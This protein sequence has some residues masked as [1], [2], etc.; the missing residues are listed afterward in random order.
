M[1]WTYF[2]CH[3]PLPSLSL[4]TVLG[5][6]R[7]HSPSSSLKPAIKASQ[8]P[9]TLSRSHPLACGFGN[10]FATL[11]GL[12][13]CTHAAMVLTPAVGQSLGLAGIASGSGMGSASLMFRHE[14]TLFHILQAILSFLDLVL[15]LSLMTLFLSLLLFAFLLYSEP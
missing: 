15:G 4:F 14:F 3:Q 1:A 7:E 10:G 12:G 8:S 2:L 5:K 13:A 9:Y 6:P 11:W